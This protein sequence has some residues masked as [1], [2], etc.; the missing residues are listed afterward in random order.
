MGF[1]VNAT[2]STVAIVGEISSSVANIPT[3]STI[4]QKY[5]YDADGSATLY[6]V[7]AGKKLMVTSLTYTTL[8]D[9]YIAIGDALSGNV[10][11]SRDNAISLGAKA[12][13]S[14]T[15]NF[16]VPF[17]ILTS[18]KCATS[19]SSGCVVSFIGYEVDE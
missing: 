11:T 7:T 19:G 14:A 13:C 16:L 5:I 9:D 4:V 8:A 17:Q 3:G 18:L 10:V 2:N 1:A 6:T 15:V 12:N